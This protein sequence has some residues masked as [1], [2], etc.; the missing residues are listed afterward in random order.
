MKLF[1]KLLGVDLNR[2]YTDAELEAIK[3]RWDNIL[4]NMIVGTFF[5]CAAIA[6]IV[7][8]VRLILK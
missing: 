5:L 4:R 8:L 7:P 3:E 6:I 2:N 1:A